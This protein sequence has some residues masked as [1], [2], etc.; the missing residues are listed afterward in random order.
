ME[1]QARYLEADIHSREQSL[2]SLVR[3]LEDLRITIVA[4]KS[5]GKESGAELK[6]NQLGMF[7]QLRS[8][9]LFETF[10]ARSGSITG[11]TS[12]IT[13]E[14]NGTDYAMGRYAILIN[15]NGRITI[16][17][18]DGGGGGGRHCHPHVS[19]SG[20]PCLGNLSSSVPKL[21]GKFNIAETFQVLR[22]FL[23][24]YCPEG[25]YTRIV[26]WGAE[27]RQRAS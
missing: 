14:D 24:S 9:G 8:A 11:V 10:T 18:I 20:A 16:S 23:S 1:E 22:S 17:S 6:S 7:E 13:I 15:F 12:P 4:K 25:A 3:Q 26:H 5:V 2:T 21:I 19:P 27:E